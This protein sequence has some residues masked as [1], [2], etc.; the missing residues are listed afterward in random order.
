MAPGEVFNMARAFYRDGP[1]PDFAAE[2]ITE[3][4]LRQARRSRRVRF[5]GWM[6]PDRADAAHRDAPAVQLSPRGFIVPRGEL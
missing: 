2:R 5:E 6:A 3:F 4:L 1:P